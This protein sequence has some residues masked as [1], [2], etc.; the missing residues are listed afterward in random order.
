MCPAP[1]GR[2]FEVLA[3]SF[4]N[5]KERGKREEDT[6]EK[7]EVTGG[8][9]GI[10][11]ASMLGRLYNCCLCLWGLGLLRQ[12]VCFGEVHLQDVPL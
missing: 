11:N 2:R 1:K 4:G 5:G 10:W 3:C 7:Q 12:R 6:E 9:R 8:T